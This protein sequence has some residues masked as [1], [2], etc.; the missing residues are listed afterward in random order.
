[1][2]ICRSLTVSLVLA[3]S[4]TANAAAGDFDW[5]NNFNIRA[6]ADR[7]GFKA[8]MATRFKVGDEQASMVIG[9]VK[10]PSDAYIALRLAEIA[11]LPFDRVIKEYKSGQGW[12][13][14]A[15]NLG[16]KPGSPEFHALKSGQ[17]LYVDFSSGE[18][19]AKGKG[20]K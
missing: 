16:V 3:L 4:V 6:E 13:V 17:D 10:S 19:K 2:K 12:G 18:G 5:A 9:N 14:I 1:M 15:K 11:N 8:R 20:K 7:S